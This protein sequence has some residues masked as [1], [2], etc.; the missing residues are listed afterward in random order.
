LTTERETPSIDAQQV[1]SAACLPF[2]LSPDIYDPGLNPL[3]RDVL[4]SRV[5]GCRSFLDSSVVRSRAQPKPTFPS[6]HFP[7][8]SGP[9]KAIDCDI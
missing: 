3:Y 9:R 1:G 8:S 5:N 6:T 2:Q 4:E 7:C